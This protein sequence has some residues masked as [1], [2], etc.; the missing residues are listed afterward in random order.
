MKTLGYIYGV[1]LRVMEGSL[2]VEEALD[3]IRAVLT[4]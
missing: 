2:T 1:I 3:M 4:I